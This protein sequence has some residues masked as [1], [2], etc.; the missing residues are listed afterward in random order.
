MRFLN[1]CAKSVVL[2]Q[3]FED[4]GWDAWT[5]D[6]LPSEGWHKHIQDDVLN[7][8]NDGWDF[9]VFHQDCTYL[10]NSGVRW[11]VER[12]EWQEIREASEF[13][14]AVFLSCCDIVNFL[15]DTNAVKVISATAINS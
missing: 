6:V 11:R 5:C 13:F 14:N 12:N 1:G 15:A 7:H 2:V 3:A 8:L 9:G 4:M 10:A